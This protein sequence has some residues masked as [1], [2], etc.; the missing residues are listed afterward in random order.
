MVPFT[1]V[2]ALLV[3]DFVFRGVGRL[4]GPR[5]S[6]AVAAL[7]LGVLSLAPA[8]RALATSRL[9]ATKDSRQLAREWISAHIPEGSRIAVN[10]AFMYGKPRLPRGYTYADIESPGVR[11]LLL[12]RSPL[13]KYS[14][15]LPPR[16]QELLD[17]RGR[18]EV[19]FDPF[20]S[21]GHGRAEYDQADAFYLPV[22]GLRAVRRPGPLLEIYRLEERPR[23]SAGLEGRYFGNLD[24][25]GDPDFVRID[26]AIDFD[27]EH[28]EPLGTVFF[29]VEWTGQLEITHS[30]EYSFRLESDDGSFLDIDGRQ[31]I[32][33][34]G[35]HM[36][37]SKT[38]TGELSRGS[39]RI[40]VRYFNSAFAG[41]VHLY[42][43][44]P[45]RAE[46]LL[47]DA[48]LKPPGP[49]ASGST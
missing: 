33:N 18:L 14:P 48:V 1:P 9:L 39:H 28:R 20:A 36:L 10:K 12:D 47:P 16:A 29:S 30:G 43:T 34:G 19:S 42:W 23:A 37:I 27:W 3:A 4:F 8:Y 25:S 24:W 40:R 31:V 15:P 35:E 46:E 38:W 41:G 2:I 13:R 22:A 26:S 11:W 45:G 6:L 32:D 17:E 5:R 44:A 21:A 49:G 7:V